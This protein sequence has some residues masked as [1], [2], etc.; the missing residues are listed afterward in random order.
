MLTAPTMEAMAKETKN[1]MMRDLA[2]FPV[3]S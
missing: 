1:G 2:D 3:D